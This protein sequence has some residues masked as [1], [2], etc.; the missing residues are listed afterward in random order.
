MKKTLQQ[1][2]Y[3]VLPDKTVRIVDPQHGIEAYSA[4]ASEQGMDIFRL[5]RR[6]MSLEQYYM[7]LKGKGAA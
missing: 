3:Q 5:E 4:L 2:R 1:N 7:E 6:R